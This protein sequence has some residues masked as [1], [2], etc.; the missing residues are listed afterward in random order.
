MCVYKE[1]DIYTIKAHILFKLPVTLKA[2][3]V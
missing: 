3:D 1:E 2:Y